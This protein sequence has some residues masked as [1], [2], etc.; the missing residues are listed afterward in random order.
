MNQHS[1]FIK[2]SITFLSAT[3][4]VQGGDAVMCCYVLFCRGGRA[5]AAAAA[6]GGG[7]G[8]GGGWGCERRN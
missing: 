7:G 8:V 2:R 1:S 5:S 6:G 3:K 4:T